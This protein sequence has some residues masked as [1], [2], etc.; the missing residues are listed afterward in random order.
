MQ[1]RPSSPINIFHNRYTA[2]I[3]LTLSLFLTLFASFLTY[4]YSKKIAEQR[5]NFRVSEI[6]AAIEDR[7][8]FYQQALQGG[9]GLFNSSQEITREEFYQYVDNLTI[10]QYLPGIQGIGYSIPV[11]KEDKEAHIQSIR[12]EGF[13]E[14]TIKPE[15]ERAE[16]SAIIFLEPF[17]WRNQRAFGYD[18]WSNEIRRQAMSRAMDT[19]LPATSGIIT[20]VQETDKNTQ[21]GFLMYL[22]VYQKGLPKNTVEERRKA[23]QGWGI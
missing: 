3:I 2:W 4:S 7:M 14:Y 20:L 17:D 18:M 23:F 22:P 8:L 11:K 15:T 10:Q 1:K 9:V 21:R 12:A 13:P 16:Y 6:K 19:G 5:F